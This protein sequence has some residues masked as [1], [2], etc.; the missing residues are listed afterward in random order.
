MRTLHYRV[1]WLGPNLDPSLPLAER[2]IYT[3]WHENML[4][5]AQRYS[6][7]DICV[8]VS[9]HADGELIAGVC[10]RLGFGL[11]RGSTARG[12]VGAVRQLIQAGRRT[13]LAVTPDGPRGPRRTAQPGVLY[14]AS[15]LDIPIVPVGLGYQRCWRLG[16][17]DRF[18][19]PQP[20]SAAT[21]VVGLP[22][23]VP[24]HAAGRLARY[25]DCLQTCLDTVT[26]LAERRARNEKPPQAPL[27]LRPSATP[28]AGLA[29]LA[30]GEEFGTYQPS[31]D[32]HRSA[33]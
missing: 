15:Q 31:A 20:F 2:Y 22:L 12:G 30:T 21:C 16:S 19:V 18:V 28:P 9:R 8:L 11:V 1:H 24:A 5:P 3:F 14:L 33:A 10:R 7:L 29:R 17:W 27:R 25:R 13:H 4:L 23:R 26:S 32:R 6:G